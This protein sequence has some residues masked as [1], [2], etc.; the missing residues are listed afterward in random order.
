MGGGNRHEGNPKQNIEHEELP[1]EL[2][3]AE[4][5]MSKSLSNSM[6]IGVTALQLQHVKT[7]Q[8]GTPWHRSEAPA[9]SGWHSTK[10]LSDLR[11]IPATLQSHILLFCLV[12][13][14][15]PTL[16]GQAGQGE[17]TNQRLSNC[18]WTTITMGK[19]Q[20]VGGFTNLPCASQ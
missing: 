6:S 11:A 15:T 20:G 14:T 5:V 1:L 4:D 17:A 8:R 3:T 12:R 19:Q 7:H 10:W 2:K 18:T 16:P 9:M 13:H